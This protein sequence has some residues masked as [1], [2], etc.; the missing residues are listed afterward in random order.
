M[1]AVLILLLVNNL[2]SGSPQENLTHFA[3]GVLAETAGRAEEARDIYSQALSRDSGN[4]FLVRKVVA[5]QV[6]TDFPSA[7]A[8][9]R[10]YAEAHRDNLTAQVDYAA[11]LRQ[12]APH[13]EL[14]RRSAL[15]TLELAHAR[16]PH[17]PAV[18]PALINLYENLG[19]REK[20]LTLLAQELAA[21]RAD[22]D[23]WLALAPLVET[24]YPADSEEFAQGQA[25]VMTQLELSGLARP[26]LARRVS[27]YH[28]QADRLPAAIAVLQKHLAL[29]PTSHSL[30]IRLGL[31]QLSAGDRMAG[32]DTLLTVVAIDPDQALAHQSL[33]RLFQQEGD[34]GKALFH[35]AETLRIRGGRPEEALEL[36][37]EYLERG[38]AHEARLL[39]EKFR[40]H[41]P[42][43]AGLQARLAIA[44]LRDGLTREA[45]R[46]FRQAEKLAEESG[47]PAD[48]RYLDTDFQ[49]E[50][51][52][53]LRAAGDHAAAE[54]R[55]RQAAQGINL[56]AEPAKYARAITAL[57]AL[58]L[59]EGKNEAPAKALLQRALTLD[60]ENEEARAL[61]E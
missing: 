13:D 54:T 46:Q 2:L 17:H 16:F 8:T 53:S 5:A 6:T 50:F 15:Q 36:A 12:H 19:D 31:L 40:F 47:D 24:L 4:Y 14:A 9:L 61:L 10:N 41:H 59:A 51:A 58:W 45:A 20:S 3:R 43:H 60:P 11:Y 25:R 34:P 49:L 37:D 27:E 28:R 39:L 57:A 26:D 55:L 42:D 30:R 7:T 44:T 33:G 38:Q 18:F 29:R 22:P 32:R 1:R 35:R 21:E 23:H 56:D 52:H 48:A